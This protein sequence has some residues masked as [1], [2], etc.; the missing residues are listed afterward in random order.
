MLT[1]QQN[2]QKVIELLQDVD[3]QMKELM[4]DQPHLYLSGHTI[5][6]RLCNGYAHAAGLQMDESLPTQ[7]EEKIML[8]HVAGIPI[9]AR[10]A[11]PV[12]GDAIPLASEEDQLNELVDSA[13][14]EFSDMDT[15]VILESFNE[16]I[17]RG[18]AVKAGLPYTPTEPATIGMFE[19]N[20]IK[21]KLAEAESAK[22]A[23]EEGK[24][25]IKAPTKK[26]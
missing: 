2:T 19:V 21:G 4:A 26:K 14:A 13:M 7:M 12:P 5:I 3:L 15:T 1:Q 24:E 9:V 16:L 6:K 17:I 8:T 18:V 25:T 22:L 20:E 23:A 10:P 11:P